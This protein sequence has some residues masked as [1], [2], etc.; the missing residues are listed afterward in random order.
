MRASLYMLPWNT[1]SLFKE[2]GGIQRKAQE[3]PVSSVGR[4]NELG[5]IW[6]VKLESC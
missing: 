6:E 2:G 1:A 4:K 5:M 3:V